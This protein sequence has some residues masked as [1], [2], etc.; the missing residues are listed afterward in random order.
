MHVCVRPSQQYIISNVCESNETEHPE[1]KKLTLPSVEMVNSLT[2]ISGVFES[3]F[4][5]KFGK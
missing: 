3:K 5:Q 4:D 2:I 1:E